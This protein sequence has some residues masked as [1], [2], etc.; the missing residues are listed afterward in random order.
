MAHR[1][2]A[3]P[4]T[5]SA[6]S[7]APSR[8]PVS[9]AAFPKAMAATTRETAISRAMGRPNLRR[10]AS[11]SPSPVTRPRRAAISWRTRVASS[12]KVSAQR[13]V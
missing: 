13:R 3:P 4:H 1:R 7:A 8:L 5:A 9:Y 2:G 12:E 10:T 6:P 11:P